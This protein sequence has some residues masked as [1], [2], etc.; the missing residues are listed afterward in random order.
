MPRFGRASLRRRETLHPLL[1]AL[2]DETIKYR[3]FTVAYGWRGMKDQNRQYDSGTS[4]LKWPHSKHNNM[5]KPD[6]SIYQLTEGVMPI[7]GK[8]AIPQSLAV[9]VVPYFDGRC[10]WDE[11]QAIQ[12]VGYML[13]VA[14][15][16]EIILRWGLDWDMDRNIMETNFR[17]AYHLELVGV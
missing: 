17:D 14:D 9:D 15:E 3:D 2:V 1:K 12:L 5:V 4:M 6:G 13:R 7:I 16:L 8:D 11:R 10:I